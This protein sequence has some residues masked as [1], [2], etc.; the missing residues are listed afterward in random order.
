M[1]NPMYA[2]YAI[3]FTLILITVFDYLKC[4]NARDEIV[5]SLRRE[6]T[7]LV[8]KNLAL[9]KQVL[10]LKK[11]NAALEQQLTVEKSYQSFRD[12]NAADRIAKLEAEIRLK[13]KM[14]AQKWQTAK[15][16]YD[17]VNG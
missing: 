12:N 1:F 6:N 15:A 13:D 8:N 17:V 14:L 2:I 3:V 10:A 11:K 7:Q 5:K 9:D 16:A 4:L